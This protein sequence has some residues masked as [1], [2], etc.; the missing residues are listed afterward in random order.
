MCRSTRGGTRAQAR[1]PALHEAEA[2]GAGDGAH[3][4][5]HLLL[6]LEE[7]SERGFAK[8]LIDGGLDRAPEGADRAID[9]SGAD[10]GLAGV[11]VAEVAFEDAAA[12]EVHDVANHNVFGRTGER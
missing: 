8:D 6:F 4:G 1:R 7:V 10:G 5:V 2:V 11:A 12:E 9:A 3:P